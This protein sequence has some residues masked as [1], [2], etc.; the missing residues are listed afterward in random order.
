MIYRVVAVDEPSQNVHVRLAMISHD[1]AFDGQ[2]AKGI[3]RLISVAEV[4]P[5]FFYSVVYEVHLL[6]GYYGN[7]LG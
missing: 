6:G 2:C 5:S 3:L 7:D 1:L 4:I